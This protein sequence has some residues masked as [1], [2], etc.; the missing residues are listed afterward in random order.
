M[1]QAYAS[2][3]AANQGD[4]PTQTR[5]NTYA[6]RLELTHLVHP[7]LLDYLY[8]NWSTI[9]R[10]QQT[11]GVL[12]LM[13]SVIHSLWMDED[14]SLMIMPGTIPLDDPAVRSEFTKFLGAA[15]NNIIESEIDGEN[16]G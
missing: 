12:R 3:Y 10:F 2:L 4:F 13:A 11:R 8:R 1:L 9:P 7:E 15:W 6:E 5:E 14:R 16:R